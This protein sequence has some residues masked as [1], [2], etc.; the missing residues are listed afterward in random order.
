MWCIEGSCPDGI[1]MPGAQRARKDGDR[2]RVDS[3]K[4]YDASVA[5]STCLGPRHLHPADGGPA[6][7]MARWGSDAVF[8]FD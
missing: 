7:E 5:V 3:A 8:A 6:E 4:P 2:C 1:P